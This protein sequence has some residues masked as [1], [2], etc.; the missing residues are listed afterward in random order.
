MDPPRR[1]VK[2]D[3]SDPLRPFAHLE[4]VIEFLRD[5]GNPP[6]TRDPFVL[7]PDGWRCDLTRPI[8]FADLEE[9]FE[10]PDSIDR[11][12]DNDSILCRNSWCYVVGA[13]SPDAPG[14]QS[15]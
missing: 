13:S 10:F 4:P 9:T 1:R 12:P 6:T 5:R 8:N 3:T 15:D 7:Y 2:P 14:R 11:S